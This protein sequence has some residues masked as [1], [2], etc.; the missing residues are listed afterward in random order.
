[1]NL[2]KHIVSNIVF[3]GNFCVI[4]IDGPTASGKTTMANELVQQLNKKQIASF[5]YR[6]DWTLID[7]SARLAHLDSIQ[8]DNNEFE[9]E[10]EL[11][12]D[13]RRASGFLQQ[14]EDLRYSN[15]SVQTIHLDNLYNR[16]DNG[17]CTGTADAVITPQMVIVVEGHYTHHKLLRRYFDMNYL[18]V[19]RRNELL[20]RKT[21][22]VKGY[23]SASAA[24]EY[25]A[26]VD[27]PSF[28]HYLLQHKPFVSQ[29]YL[30]EEFNNQHRLSFQETEMLLFS[31]KNTRPGI[32]AI[33]PF[34]AQQLNRVFASCHNEFVT[35]WGIK[36][37]HRHKQLHDALHEHCQGLQ[38]NLQYARYFTAH[39]NNFSYHYGIQA[40]ETYVM[41]CG[42]LHTLHWVA[43]NAMNTVMYQMACNAAGH[44][45][46]ELAVLLG[47]AEN[48][49]KK[50]HL[51]VPNTYFVP[52]FFGNA[53]MNI[54]CYHLGNCWSENFDAI[55]REPS[56]VI[57]RCEQSNEAAFFLQFL[58][59]LGFKLQQFGAYVFAD[60][61][62][63]KQHHN[64]FDAF[65]EKFKGGFSNM[66][67]ATH[68]NNS[69][70]EKLNALLCTIAE[71]RIVLPENMPGNEIVDF[72]RSLSPEKKHVFTEALVESYGD[73]ALFGN[74]NIRRYVMALPTQLD[75]LYF[76]LSVSKMGAVPFIT[77]YDL[78]ESGIDIQEYFDYFTERGRPFGL[79]A[80]RNAL[81][82][83][84]HSGYLMKKGPADLADSV[85]ANLIRFLQQ[86][87]EETLPPW[88]LGIDHA[89]FSPIGNSHEKHFVDEAL[90]TG[91][92]HSICIDVS[93][94]TAEGPFSQ[95]AER[96]NDVFVWLFQKSGIGACDLELYAAG[97]KKYPDAASNEVF[98]IY[99][100]LCSL[101]NTQSHASQQAH[102]F[103]FGPLLGTVHHKLHPR[104]EA[105]L[106]ESIF[107]EVSQYGFVGNVVHG[108][109][110]T[111]Q[112]AIEQLVEKHCV[113]VNYAGKFLFAIVEGL[114]NEIKNTLGKG[115]D[116]IKQNL[117]KI[118]PPQFN[119]CH[120]NIRQ[121]LHKEL[122]N[123]QKACFEGE[124]SPS[125]IAWFR[126]YKYYL[127]DNDFAE[128]V[129]QINLFS[130]TPT[131]VAAGA[132]LLASMIEVP[133]AEFIDNMASRV[134]AAGI[135]H[136]HIDIGDGSFISR[137]LDGI[138]K[139]RYLQKYHP[140]VNTH[141]HFMVRNPFNGN[142]S[143][144][145][146]QLAGT[147]K[148]SL[149]YLHPEAYD[150]AVSWQRGVAQIREIHCQAGVVLD[151]NESMLP[152]VFF[153]KMRQA[154][155][156]HLL[157]MG[158]PIGR[159]GQAFRHE[160]I[161]KIRNA[162]AWAQSNNYEIVI[163]VDGG[164]SEGVLNACIEAGA[165]FL[166]GWS[167]FLKYGALH[168]E[169]RIHELLE[170]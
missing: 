30:N 95:I 125:E 35:L 135:H 133:Y 5:V 169:K 69:E 138:E 72:Y 132:H 152:E 28:R 129:K 161:A 79:Q 47:P 54:C 64:D 78:S 80:S 127:P 39:S 11:H 31:Q 110:F 60:N 168:I 121:N 77:V 74:V 123:I 16:D 87:P 34:E 45:D 15:F 14:I 12:M 53:S 111:P 107:R 104:L 106:S 37:H 91:F 3:N 2:I 86:R 13:L 85:K 26:H 115:Q 150:T 83:E 62:F 63:S 149:I 8:H 81:G 40:G 43:V 71:N 113:R 114:S 160:T 94:I 20:Q 159:G 1:M 158:V 89:I 105:Q 55:F 93:E 99:A 56:F 100:Q 88:N 117:W 96:L 165:R 21:A 7:R 23:R 57:H 102:Y 4:G 153:E 108:T 98:A 142:G 44:A 131:G 50:P 29:M 27:I 145:M 41:V 120:P 156:H 38:A 32:T 84:K 46:S 143:K 66:L 167:M 164:L 19:A 162:S 52:Y 119:A 147:I 25:F 118:Q 116:E 141:L 134:I 137:K 36:A 24:A 136:F 101:F 68:W 140:Q 92:I 151:V 17:K 112:K 33:D 18:L 148:K 154:D 61:L 90:S 73:I 65:S 124:F 128:A 9:F 22:R 122:E 48:T 139:L 75:E 130:G 109:S 82:T 10:A 42:N 51:V 163:E 103:I 146:V 97:E 170:P 155:I 166:S 70:R 76:A 144:S 6:L 157:V 58:E 67:G 59:H 126:Q 49:E